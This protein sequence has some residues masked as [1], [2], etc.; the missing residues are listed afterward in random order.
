M[1]MER[2][3]IE[4]TNEKKERIIYITANDNAISQDTKR[5]LQGKLQRNGFS[6][7]KELTEDAELIVCIGGD[8]TLLR[9]L[10]DLDFPQIPI[11][12]VN[13]GHLGFFQEIMPNELDTFI[14]KYHKGNYQI[15]QLRLVKAIVETSMEKTVLMGLNEIT[16]KGDR[17]RSLH[18]NL[19]LD[20]EFMER[21]SGDGI[22]VC[23]PAGSTAYNYALGGCI[24]DPGLDLLQ[25]TPIS[26]MNSTAYRSFTSSVVV[27]PQTCV[28]IHPEFTFEKSVLVVVDGMEY[29]FDE[30]IGISISFAEKS[31]CLVR[32]EDYDF[33]SKVKSKFL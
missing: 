6:I 16:V 30:I 23:T 5:I 15:Q 24:V 3:R 25:V 17:S 28:R 13:T 18:L 21:F 2:E 20:N 9:T 29:R 12:G 7:R 33:W 32:F 26:P 4:R 14:E 22:L 1:T 8:G 10:K 27:P 31:V 11:I 19:S